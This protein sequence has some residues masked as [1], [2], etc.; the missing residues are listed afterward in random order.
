M[1]RLVPFETRQVNASPDPHLFPAT[2][3]VRFTQRNTAAP[4]P[5]PIRASDFNTRPSRGRF[6][7]GGN[8]LSQFIMREGFERSTV[9]EGI[10]FKLG[11]SSGEM[12]PF[13]NPTGN[14]QSPKAMAWG[15]I[16]DKVQAGGAW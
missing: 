8:S 9:R 5:D 16:L 7:H 14:M 1:G 6:F 2:A 13:T 12:L 10:A 4:V 11:V 15:N 3:N